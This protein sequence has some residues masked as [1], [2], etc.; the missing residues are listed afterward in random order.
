MAKG[1]DTR[2]LMTGKDGKLYIT[3]GGITRWYA[4][5]EEFEINANFT[6]T[7]FQPAGDYQQYAVPTSVKYTLSFTEAVIRDDLLLIPLLNAA[8]EGKAPSFDFKADATEPFAGGKE[9]FTLNECVPDGDCN[10][11]SVK[12]GEIIKRQNSFVINSVPE[13]ISKLAGM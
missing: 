3:V 7:D 4:C 10:L 12:P 5:V 9:D 11:L 2:K 1:F 13:C 8:K 6:N